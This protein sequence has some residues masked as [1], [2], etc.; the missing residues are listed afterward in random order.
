M[1]SQLQ[2]NGG[3]SYLADDPRGL[4]ITGQRRWIQLSGGGRSFIRVTTGLK[5]LAKKFIQLFFTMDDL[6]TTLF[7]YEVSTVLFCV[8]IFVDK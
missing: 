7:L 2:D 8:F 4:T 5:A 1:A 6:L 3:Y